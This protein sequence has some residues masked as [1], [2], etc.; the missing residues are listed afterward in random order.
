MNSVANTL[1]HGLV[2]TKF[3]AQIART[4]AVFCGVALAVFSLITSYGIDLSPGLF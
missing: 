2:G 3:D 1:T 4:I